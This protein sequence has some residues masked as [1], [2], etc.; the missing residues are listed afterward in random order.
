MGCLQCPRHLRGH[1]V[2]ISD[3]E[4]GPF[5]WWKTEAGWRWGACLGCQWAGGTRPGTQLVFNRWCLLVQIYQPINNRINEFTCAVTHSFIYSF[6]HL[7]IKSSVT[8]PRSQSFIRW[9]WL[10]GDLRSGPAHP[11]EDRA[12]HRAPA[13]WEQVQ[14]R[15]RGLR[16]RNPEGEGGFH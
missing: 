12:R 15:K 3:W 13:S 1:S 7:F 2:N 9:C 11:W 4:A 14:D 16:Y 6:T 8:G 5:H 10:S